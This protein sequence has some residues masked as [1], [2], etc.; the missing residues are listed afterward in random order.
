MS[1]SP[2]DGIGVSLPGYY[3]VWGIDI[4]YGITII[5]STLSYSTLRSMEEGFM[6]VFGVKKYG[7]L[8]TIELGV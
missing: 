5:G 3:V 1:Y 2:K 8:V 7:V 6:E 4:S